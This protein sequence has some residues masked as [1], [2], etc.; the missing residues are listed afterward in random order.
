MPARY[1]ALLRAINVGGHT[2]T[3][4]RLRELLGSLAVSHVQT[5]IASG[6]VIF[7][8]S[9]T[10]ASLETAIEARLLKALGYEV[11]TFLRSQAEMAAVAG[12]APFSESDLE[13][14]S[15]YVAFLKDRPA[16]AATGKLMSL[17]NDLDDFDVHGREVFWLRRKVKER[18]GEP[19][20]PL[21]R[22][23][24]QPATT[25]NITTVRKI[26]AKYCQ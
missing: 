23:L 3:M 5:F 12:H 21:E 15:V 1:I 6:N 2:V 11:L 22:V 17:R 14:A 19:G 25:R 7:E 10:P 8:S 16:R 26:A 9:G 24:A 20:P 18:L 13:G 4:A